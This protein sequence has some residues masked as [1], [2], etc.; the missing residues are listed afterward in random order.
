MRCVAKGETPRVTRVYEAEQTRTSAAIERVWRKHQEEFPVPASQHL[1][2]SIPRE[3]ERLTVKRGTS[4]TS[5]AA[6]PNSCSNC[7]TSTK[8]KLNTPWEW[9][10]LSRLSLIVGLRYVDVS[11]I[12]HFAKSL[13]TIYESAWSEEPDCRML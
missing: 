7:R 3:E 12:L 1:H 6:Q 9:S 4:A 11:S 2:L 8:M 10:S 5:Q 13:P